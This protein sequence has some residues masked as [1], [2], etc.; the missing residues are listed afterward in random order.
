MLFNGMKE[1]NDYEENCVRGKWIFF[2]IVNDGCFSTFSVFNLLFGAC[3]GHFGKIFNENF[4]G[5][6]RGRNPSTTQNN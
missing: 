1:F 4:D 5:K 3:N 6:M 2:I